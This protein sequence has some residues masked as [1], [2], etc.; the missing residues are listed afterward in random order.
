MIETKYFFIVFIWLKP[1]CNRLREVPITIDFEF[2]KCD[3]KN[4]LPTY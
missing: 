4:T 3:I 1:N 2:G